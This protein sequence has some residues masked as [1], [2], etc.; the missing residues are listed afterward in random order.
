MGTNL[1][2]MNNKVDIKKLLKETKSTLKDCY[3][4]LNI[5]LTESEEGYYEDTARE[6]KKDIKII[7]DFL[8]Q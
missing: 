7:N 4:F 8:E 6:C 2:E 5:P 3:Y 1:S